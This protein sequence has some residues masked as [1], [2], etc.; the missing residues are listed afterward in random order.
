LYG[1][2]NRDAV[3]L[4]SKRIE[5][6]LPTCFAIDPSWSNERQQALLLTG[7]F[8]VYKRIKG[9]APGDIEY[10]RTRVVNAGLD[11]K[12]ALGGNRT[13][14]RVEIEFLDYGYKRNV[15][16]LDLLFSKQPQLLQNIPILCSQYIVLGIWCDWDES[17]LQVVRQLLLNNVVSIQVDA[18]QLCGQKFASVRWKDFELYEF[19]VQQKQI[20]VPISKDLIMEH[21]KKL[22]K[23]APQSPLVE[24][25]NNNIQSGAAKTPTDVA[26]E[27]LAARMSLSARLDVHRTLNVAAP[28]P[29]K[30]AQAE[31]KPLLATPPMV[32]PTP[33]ANLTNMMPAPAA[34]T[35][36]NPQAPAFTPG[37]PYNS[38]RANEIAAAAT[39]RNVYIPKSSPRPLNT[40]YNV[41]LSKPLPAAQP[42][43]KQPTLSY[44]PPR[45][46][47]TPT[48]APAAAAATTPAFR[49]SLL[50]V[51][52]SYDVYVSYVENGPHLFWVQLQSAAEELNAMMREIEH[53]RPQPLTQLPSVG[54]ACLANF[55]VDGMCYRALISAVYPH[56]FRVVYV[57]YGNSETV[58]FKDIYQIPAPLLQIKPFAFRF[59]LTGAKELGALDESMKR[60]FKTSVQY[61]KF[62]LIVYAAESV[63]SMQTCELLLE[64]NSMLKVLKELLNS[65]QAYAKAEQL[66]NDD[67]VEIRYIDS[68]SN[69]YVQKVEHIKQFEQLMDEM[70]AY[71]NTNQQ[72]PEH[73]ILGAPCVVK[74]DREWYRA[75]IIRAEDATV[76]VRHVDFG[77]EQTVKRHLIGNIAKKHLLMPRQAIKCCLKGFENS[78]LSQEN[79]TDQ[80]EMLAE[81]S[82]IRRRT[83][84][85]RVFRIEPDGLNVVNLLAK[86]LNVMKKLYKLSMPFEQ[87]LSLEKGQFNSSVVSDPKLEMGEILNSTTVESEDRMQLQKQQARQKANGNDWDKHSSASATSSKDT[88]SQRSGGGIK[89]SQPAA[90]P[91]D[92]N[93]DTHSTSS[94]TSGMSSPRKSNRRQERQRNESPRLQNGKAEKNTRFSNNQSPRKEQQQQAERSSPNQRSQNAPQGYAQK[95]LRQKSTLDG[96][97]IG[98]SSK[99]SSGVES[100]APS[101]AESTSSGKAAT[102]PAAEHYMPLD[103][104]YKQLELK[105]PRKEAVSLSWWVSPFQ[106]YVV[107][108]ALAAK[109]EQLLQRELKQFYRQKPHQPLQLKVNS[110]V[111]VRQRKDNTILRGTVIACNHMLRKYR[112]YS[113][114]TGCLLT[115][116]SEDVWQ[117]EQRFAEP[118]CLAQRCSFQNIITNYDHLYIVDRMAQY[119]PTNAKVDCEFVGKQSN[120]YIVNIM[121]NGQA[122][123]DTLIKQQF[124]TEVAPQVLVALLAGQQVRGTFTSIRDMTNFKIQLDGCSNVNFLCS[125]DDSK[126]VK[127]NKDIAKSFKQHYEGKSYALNIKHVCENNIIHLRPVMPLLRVE[128]THYICNY[129]ILL[130]SFEATVVYTAKAYRIFVQPSAVQQQMKQLLNEMYEFYKSSGKQLRK[131]EKDLTCAAL[132]EDG[133]WYRARVLGKDAKGARIEVLYIDY[134]NTEQLQRE[135]LKQLEQ[136]FSKPSCFGVEVNLPMARIQQEEKLKTRLAQLLEEQLVTVKPVEVRRSH[137]IADVH[138]LQ[139]KE[140]LL[141]KLK[142]EKLIAGRDLDYMRKQLDKEKPH[143]HEYIECVDLTTDDDEQEQQQQEHQQSNKAAAK[144]KKQEKEKQQPAEQPAPVQPTPPPPPAEVQP[145]PE[146]TPAA[147]AAAASPTPDPYKD[148]ETAVLSHCDNPAHFYVHSMDALPALKRLTENLQIVSPSLPQ[149]KEIVNGAECISMYSMDKSWYRAK[150]IDAELMVLQFIDF[151]NTDCVSDAKDIKQSVSNMKPCCLPFA[152][153][154]AP[155][156]S[157]EWADAANGIFNDSY[158]K[159]LHYEYLTEGDW[160]TRS[161]V[162]LYINGVDVAQKL[163]DDGYARPLQC[164]SPGSSG[165]V[166]H[167]NSIED[168]YVQLESDFKALELLDLYLSVA[169]KELQPVEKYEKGA[170]VAALFDD[171]E[172]YYRAELLSAQPDAD[173]RYAVRFID[174]GNSSSSG[175]CLALNE[176]LTTLRCLSKRCALQLPENYVCWSQAAQ[177]KFV[178][179]SGDLQFTLQLVQPGLK[180]M[181][182]HLL[183]DG[184]NILDKLLPLCEQK[185][186]PVVATAAAEEAAKPLRAVV[187]HMDSPSRIYL[188]YE[189]NNAQ[190]DLVSEQLNSEQSQLQLKRKLAQL[191]ELCVAQYAEDKEYYRS[192]VLELLPTQ[193]AHQYRVLCIDYGHQTLVSELYELPAAVAQLPPLAELHALQFELQTPAA[194]KALDALFDSCN[195]E[196]SVELLNK[197]AQPP[198]V[199]LSTVDSGLDIAQQLQRVLQQELEAS[200]KNSCIISAG[201]T[202]KQFYIQMKKHTHQLDLIK[203]TL[204]SAQ[205]LPLPAPAVD[206]MAVC[207]SPEDDCYYRCCVQKLLAERSY[208]VLAID[209]GHTLVCQQLYQLPESVLNLAPLALRCQLQLPALPDVSEQQLEAAFAT[210]L[211][212]HFG[213][214]YELQSPLNE[215]DSSSLQLVELSVNYKQLAQ[216]LV[217]LLAGVQPALEVQL[218]N[219]IVV[220]Y[221]DAKSFYVQ[222]EQ[223]VPALEQLTD[224]LLDAEQQ[225]QPFTALQVG[226]LCVAQFPEDEVYYRAEIVALLDDG[227]CEVHFID[228]GN[229]AI[230]SQFR[231]LPQHLAQLPRYSKHCELDAASLAKCNVAALAAFIDTRFSETFQLEILAKQG[232]RQTHVVRL[233]YQNTNISEQLKLLQQIK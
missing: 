131:V 213:E 135:Q 33:L 43:P 6:L 150:I 86:N 195:G 84:S 57:D 15:N 64:G 154:I 208:E 30:P 72:V 174:F 121:V 146:P 38:Q 62:K 117:L 188:Q 229:N 221:D 209:Y 126:F 198:V 77:Y 173:G 178:E 160:F 10:M 144:A 202:P 223:D 220:Q 167:L 177:D 137:L 5:T 22:W 41:R 149:L 136:Q 164:I 211:E 206:L 138:L 46:A 219:C 180:K 214:V 51:G 79:I 232:E 88:H 70:F 159:I 48:H 106:F 207:F 134:G 194:H 122:L 53:M 171:D 215:Q 66:R 74:C 83:F 90:R 100:D 85:V 47:L 37:L 92:A 222:M 176:R 120:S 87:Y 142:A 157:L 26:R 75:E 76:I 168:F 60:I 111:V 61:I 36:V 197:S 1:Q 108:N 217:N 31:P 104:S 116:T 179:L 18:E 140:S 50:N 216:E 145:E 181:R 110:S 203:Q 35:Q 166:S 68:P 40:Y 2:A 128:R 13:Q 158:E 118:P 94:Y 25:N 59:A 184:E 193:Q 129:P 114:D 95:P 200:A 170:V 162:K 16:S 91:L 24:Y 156:G 182:V 80:F 101:T 147:A 132:S 98:S 11:E 107:P 4:V 151:G 45:Y 205:L 230:T 55:S 105:T 69:F 163:I 226:A 21:C 185:P 49:T 112:I 196:V 113:V 143:V 228:F 183:L 187:S 67:A 28:R 224:K 141:D 165:Y 124:L 42:M 12:Q 225:L 199:R 54:T 56:G 125:Y 190:L 189:H 233:F 148:M 39:A 17:E 123:R 23:D 191:G 175:K 119:V 52:S 212:Q 152:L 63:G 153:P 227:K 172:S 44:V 29:L 115:V 65:R 186:V 3:L 81:E 58:A 34:V 32:L 96:S 204:K 201:S 161:Y 89:R 7:T 71:Y 8:C 99:R 102:A 73:F 27:Q 155:N 130:N 218:H 169:D 109:H 9:A 20:G 210:L 103:R 192:R 93:F 14:M 231:Q 78:E 19:L 133:N 139:H 82:N 97:N 127:S